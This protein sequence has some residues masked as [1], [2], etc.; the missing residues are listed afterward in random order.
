M[1]NVQLVILTSQC[2]NK[3]LQKT[4]AMHANK[5]A[6][7]EEAACVDIQSEHVFLVPHS[8]YLMSYSS[9]SQESS[10]RYPEP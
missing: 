6:M 3:V 10:I 4:T 1:W 7:P 8:T 5:V 9:T 2:K